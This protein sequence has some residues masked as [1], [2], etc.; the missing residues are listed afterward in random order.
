MSVT[1]F[2]SRN[3]FPKHSTHQ[4]PFIF[5]LLYSESAESSSK[6]A[7]GCPEIACNA[8]RGQLLIATTIVGTTHRIIEE[9]MYRKTRDIIMS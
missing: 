6:G 3:S 4:H 5:S 8:S 2:V 1:L 9:T 7:D